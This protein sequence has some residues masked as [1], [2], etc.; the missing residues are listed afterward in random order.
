[1][2]AEGKSMTS[3]ACHGRLRSFVAPL[4]GPWPQQERISSSGGRV[5]RLCRDARAHAD[6]AG[7]DAT[8]LEYMNCAVRASCA[9]DVAMP[10]ATTVREWTLSRSVRMGAEAKRPGTPVNWFRGTGCLVPGGAPAKNRR[11]LR[12]RR[13]GR[14]LVPVPKMPGNQG[15]FWR[16]LPP[17]LLTGTLVARGGRPEFAALS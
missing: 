8:H 17:A 9:A 2:P 14:S 13:L 11:P 5:R 12:K 10:K 7:S 15:P 3:A 16:G 6:R 4:S 1:M